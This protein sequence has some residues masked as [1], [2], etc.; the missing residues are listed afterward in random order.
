MPTAAGIIHIEKMSHLHEKEKDERKV[1]ER[2]RCKEK[3]SVRRESERKSQ[4]NQPFPPLTRKE[5]GDGEK[6]RN[7]DGQISKKRGQIKKVRK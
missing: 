5:G 2:G 6:E 4:R 1:R 3:T 7:Q